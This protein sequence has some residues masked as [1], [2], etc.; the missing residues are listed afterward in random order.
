MY[1]C[2]KM[3]VNKSK[4]VGPGNNF[5]DLLKARSQLH[6]HDHPAVSCFPTCIILHNHDYAGASYA[7]FCLL[8]SVAPE[9]HVSVLVVF[10]C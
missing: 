10:S 9:C 7:K 2:P 1:F 8:E 6:D 4:F 3:L 5:C